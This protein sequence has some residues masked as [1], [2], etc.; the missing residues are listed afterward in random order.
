MCPSAPSTLMRVKPFHSVISDTSCAPQAKSAE[1]WASDAAA[2][3]T[4]PDR[5]PSSQLAT[6]TGAT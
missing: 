3:S 6:V 5:A 4:Q 1:S 2:V